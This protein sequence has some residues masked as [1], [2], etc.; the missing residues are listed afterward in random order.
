MQHL[1]VRIHDNVATVLIDRPEKHGALSPGLLFDLNEALGD[2]HQEKRARAVVLSSRGDHFCSGVD[3]QVFQ[4]IADLPESER[5]Q[6]W[7]EY[8]RAVSETCEKML[9][10][11]KPIIAA[12]DGAAIGAGFALMLASDLCVASKRATFAADAARRGLVGGVTT[13]LLSFRIGAAAAARLTLAG[14]NIDAEEAQ[15]LNLLCQSPVASDQV[16]V[17]A[18]QW[19]ARC[20]EGPAEAVQ[21]SKRLLNESVGEAL[22]TQISAAAAD[23]ASA[24]TTESA[25]E[26]VSAFLEKRKP[27]WP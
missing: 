21:A 6:Q 13:A 18:S 26:G 22:L 10:F 19:A 14:E 2:V 5:M 9:R 15:R 8:W 24:C 7:F 23:S 1:D 16:W 17:A 4:Q 27:S 12:V 20:S 3:L 25:A 11:P